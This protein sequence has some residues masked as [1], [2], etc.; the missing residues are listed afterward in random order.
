VNLNVSSTLDLDVIESTTMSR[1]AFTLM[2]TQVKVDVDVI[3][4]A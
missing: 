1:V 3:A 4:R 2:F